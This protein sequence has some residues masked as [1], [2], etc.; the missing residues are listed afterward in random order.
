MTTD[1]VKNHSPAGA[2]RSVAPACPSWGARQARLRQPS[3]ALVQRGC[4]AVVH[5]NGEF[6]AGV[7]GSLEPLAYLQEQPFAGT[8]AP[9]PWADADI[10]HLGDGFVPATQWLNYREPS[11]RP[12]GR[13]CDQQ[14]CPR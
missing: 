3:H 11:G 13:T 1:T 12:V 7:P 5:V 8:L 14:Q 10:T 9:Q 4:P 2:A 6:D